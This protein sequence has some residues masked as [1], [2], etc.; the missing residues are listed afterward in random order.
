[1][2]GLGDNEVR[3][4]RGDHVVARKT[5]RK[6]AAGRFRSLVDSGGPGGLVYLPLM[7]IANG[8]G[9]Y[10]LCQMVVG[11][12]LGRE[13]IAQRVLEN[14]FAAVARPMA[15][16]SRVGVVQDQ[17]PLGQSLTEID[18]AWT[19]LSGRLAQTDLSAYQVLVLE[20]DS[21]E[22]AACQKKIGQWIREGGRAILHGGTP[23][24]LTRVASLLPEPMALQSSTSLPVNIA[25]W[26]AAIDGLTNQELYW[27]GSRKGLTYRQVTPLSRE[28]VRHTVVAGLPESPEWTIVKADAL[29]VQA[30]KPSMH[31]GVMY[32]GAAGTVETEMEFKTT[33]QYAVG[34]VMK[35]TPLEEIY[36]MVDVLVDGRR[37]ATMSVA[38]KD[39]DLSWCSVTMEAGRH[40]IGLRFINDQWNPTT[41]EDRNM[42]IKQLQTAPTGTLKSLELLSPAALVKGS[43]GKGMV[44]VDQ[45]RWEADSGADKAGRYLSNLLTNLGA[46]FGSPSQGVRIA[47]ERFSAVRKSPAFRFR[48]GKAYMGTNGLVVTRLTF[49]KSARYQFRIRASGTP[50]QGGCCRTWH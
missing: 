9:R 47:G 46:E 10:L 44:L 18:A 5:I 34:A 6:P 22:A 41:R 42:W 43:L 12:K 40:R 32:M 37:R 50:A 4:W 7:E 19:N 8:R 33:G 36:P 20:A 3:F 26:D 48:D 30:G 38:G 25:R 23:A 14:L 17:L 11:E 16:T 21:P 31:G 39:W 35:G 49:A 2:A 1:M 13:P 28:V 29:T 15:V 27:Y 45:V 24:G